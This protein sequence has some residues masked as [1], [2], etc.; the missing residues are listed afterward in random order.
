MHACFGSEVST[1]MTFWQEL[2]KRVLVYDG[3]MGTQIFAAELSIADYGGAAFEGCHENLVF[4]RPDAIA[5]IHRN[6][7]NVGCDVVETDTFNGHPARLAEYHLEDRAYDVGKAAASIARRVADEFTAADPTRPRFVA[8]S[9]GPSNYLLSS[10]DPILSNSTFDALADGYRQ[11][12]AGLIDGGVDVLL[13]ETAQDMLDVKA[14]IFGCRAAMEQTGRRVP[15]QVQVTLDPNSGRMLLGT[16]IASVAV[17]LEALRVD[18]IGLNCS[19]GPDLMR[20]PLRYLSEHCNAKLSCLPNAG[21][22]INLGDGK[23]VFPLSPEQLA[24]AHDY[25][26][27]ELGVNAVGGCCGTTPRHIELVVE[28]VWGKPAPQRNPMSLPML[29]SG[30]SATALAQVPAPTL[31]GERVNSQGSRKAKRLL[32]NDDYDGLLDIAR[33]QVE[34]GAHTLDVLV[35]LTERNDEAE[36]LRRTVKKLST[37]V[38]APLILDSTESDVLDAALKQYPGRAAVSSINLERGLERIERVMPLV[39]AHGAAVVAL[40]IDEVGMAH[41]ADKKLEIVRRIRDIVRDRYEMRD[42]GLIFDVLVF[43]I[44]TG[45]EDLKNDAVE[46]LE[47]VRRVKLEMPDVKTLLGVSNVS[48]G[49]DP[50]PRAVLNSVFL[51]HAVQRGLDM[52]I[53][54][55]SHI[56]PYAEIPEDQRRLCDDLI[57]NRHDNALTDFIA[58]FQENTEAGQKAEAEDVTASLSPAARIHYQI[59]HRKKDGIESLIDVV[60]AERGAVP[61]LNEVLLPAMK[62]VGDKFGAGELILPFVLQSAEVMKKSVAHLEQYLEK[63]EGYTKGKVVLATVF[64]DVHD[65]G[66]SL[67]NT[68]LSNNGYTTYDL[69]KQVPV[70]TIIEKALEVGADA[71]GLSALLVSTSKQM[72]LCVKELAARGLNIPVLIGGAAINRPYGHRSLFLDGDSTKPYAGG[73][74]YCKDAFEGLETMDRL[75]GADKQAFTAEVEREARLTIEKQARRDVLSAQ[76]EASRAAELAARKAAGTAG[77]RPSGTPDIAPPTPPFWGW[78]VVDDIPVADLLPL[79]DYN[80]L[81]RLHFGAKNRSGDDYT[82]LIKDEF[83]PAINELLR[84][85]EAAPAPFL[86]PRAIYGYFPVKADGDEVVV[87]DP[88]EQTREVVRFSFPR[89]PGGE[90]LC[91]S[92]YFR[93]DT[94]DVLPLQI[95]TAGP[96]V[97]T[98]F[99]QLQKAGDYSKAYFLHGLGSSLAEGVAEY[100]N[101]R[102]R[103]ELGISRDQTAIADDTG[104]R[105]RGKRYSWGYP[106]CPDLEEQAKLFALMPAEAEI[107]VSLTDSYQ[108]VPEQTTAALVCHHPAAKYF[109]AAR[110]TLSR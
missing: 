92:D 9:I 14:A 28:R 65:I 22:P 3:A 100:M 43:P 98:L 94:I 38:D 69:G 83:E 71:I 12:A 76:T 19:T 36:Q 32:L 39:Q 58:Y 64:G 5:Q 30:L 6:Y 79:V 13:I 59:V 66:K 81:Y 1:R 90:N 25:F 2:E 41:T 88:Q 33:E 105:A 75:M 70:N 8:G 107:G 46:T 73:L 89:Q 85:N 96:G 93:Q 61:T 57:F 45:Q 17:T 16:D 86:T 29:S 91:L 50:R 97:T 11:Q 47:A 18:I 54:N 7:F 4:T 77:D 53:V 84:E 31:V 20:E 104:N 10:E 27:N 44:T 62:E 51:Y 95:V 103:D 34:G 108:L 24:D 35:P 106:S 109:S 102:V 49:I 67:V 56:T 80:T 78:R 99:E 26:V 68:I 23:A 101:A 110:L 72:P 37:V 87:Y 63:K 48:F 82:A 42:D 15:L 52:A 21:L 55:P 40:T 74:F 60:V